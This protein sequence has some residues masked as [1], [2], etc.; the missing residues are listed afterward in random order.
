ML[1]AVLHFAYLKE[2]L[3]FGSVGNLVHSFS[4]S[5]LC[6]DRFAYSRVGEVAHALQCGNADAH[7]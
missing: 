6:V 1:S 2:T 5:E 3:S 4:L 7:M